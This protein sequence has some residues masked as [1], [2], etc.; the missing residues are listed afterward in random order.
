VIIASSISMLPSNV[1]LFGCSRRTAIAARMAAT[2]VPIARQEAV[3]DHHAFDLSAAAGSPNRYDGAHQLAG[4]RALHDAALLALEPGADQRGAR[5]LEG[6]DRHL[7]MGR[8]SELGELGVE[9]LDHAQVVFSLL[10]RDEALQRL[11][12]AGTQQL[13]LPEGA[14]DTSREEQRR[15]LRLGVVRVGHLDRLT[16]ALGELEL[17]PDV[18]RP[19]HQQRREHEQRRGRQGRR[20]DERD[21]EARIQAR[22]KAPGAP[23]DEQLHG[24]AREQEDQEP[25]QDDTDV[26]QREQHRVAADRQRARARDQLLLD[27]QERR[28]HDERKRRQ[29]PVA[30]PP[31]PFDRGYAAAPLAVLRRAFAC[32]FQASATLTQGG[33]LAQADGHAWSRR[34]PTKK[35]HFAGNSPSSGA[36][37]LPKSR[38]CRREQRNR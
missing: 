25:D 7:G 4:T 15:L 28:E 5:R 30:P 13:A 2:R 29:A 11:G 19:R 20:E 26:H 1:P 6:H 31:P 35:R 33:R 23:V 12:I 37:C 24:V 34:K 32:R 18:D 21:H 14:R 9:D 22:A 27:R 38:T 10:L 8:G 16:E 17:E 3:H 36:A